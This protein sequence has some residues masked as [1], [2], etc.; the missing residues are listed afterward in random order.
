MAWEYLEFFHIAAAFIVVSGIAISEVAV[1]RARKTDDPKIFATLMGI[2]KIAGPMTGAG[3]VLAGILGV[4]TAW[5][6]GLPLTTTGWLNA[7]YAATIVALVVPPLTFLRWERAVMA[8]MPQAVQQG[9][10]LPEQKA[11]LGGPA[12]RATNLFMSALLVFIV[13]L[14]VFRPF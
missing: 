4:L 9:E 11:I 10:V 8:L 2:A 5:R 14:M 7:A 1:R 6:E 13:V 3:L 12:W